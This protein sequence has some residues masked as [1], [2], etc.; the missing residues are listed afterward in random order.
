LSCRSASCSVIVLQHTDIQVSETL[1]FHT[2]I[3]LSSFILLNSATA[4]RRVS[5][6]VF[7]PTKAVPPEAHKIK[8]FLIPLT[9]FY[10]S[11]TKL[12]LLLLL[13]IWHPTSSPS[14]FDGVQIPADW[15]TSLL[16]HPAMTLPRLL[17]EFSKVLD[18]DK[19]DREWVIRNILGGMSAGFGLRGWFSAESQALYE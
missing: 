10:S 3:L 18:D 1:A 4:L 16:S 5:S 9:L 2:G 19:L 15:L 8:I 13:T 14:S 17:S 6:I 7:P 12:F 11:L